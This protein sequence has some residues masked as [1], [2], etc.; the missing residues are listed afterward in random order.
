MAR[1][2]IEPKTSDLRVRCPTD[3]VT[4]PG[5]TFG[6]MR[7]N[8][9]T[10]DIGYFFS[11]VIQWVILSHHVNHVHALRGWSGGAML[12]GKLP[13]PGRPTNLDYSRG[14]GPTALVVGA[15]RGCFW[16]FFLSSI[17]SLFFLPARHRL[18]YCIKGLLSPKQPTTQPYIK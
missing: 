6:N 12:M 8:V 17:I 9:W 2:G 3:C 18:K 10:I 7:Q 4:R 15:S 5:N 13:V 1:P 14:Q 16:T 11:K